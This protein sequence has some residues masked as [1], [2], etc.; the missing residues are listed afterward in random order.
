MVAFCSPPTLGM[1][2]TLAGS[3]PCLWSVGPPR[4]HRLMPKV[5]PPHCKLGTPNIWLIC[6]ADKSWWSP[7]MQQTLSPFCAGECLSP[8]LATGECLHFVATAI[9]GDPIHKIDLKQIVLNS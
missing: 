5:P 8:F 7:E 4:L 3:S 6:F 2:Q 1:N 9:S